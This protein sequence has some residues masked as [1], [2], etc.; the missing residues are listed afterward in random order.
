MS[1]RQGLLFTAVALL[2]VLFSVPGSSQEVTIQ[3]GKASLLISMLANTTWPDEDAI[4]TWRVG[5]YGRDRK[6]MAVLKRDLPRYPTRGKPVTV[7]PY[8]TLDDAR[9]AHI[10][11]V[12]PGSN[13]DLKEI[14]RAL[15]GSQTLIVTDGAADLEFSM[16]NFTHPSSVRLGFEINRSNI[17]DAG[18]QLSRDMLLFGGSKLDVAAVYEETEAELERTRALARQRQQQMEA[19][20][21]ELEQQRET[22]ARQRALVAMNEEELKALGDQ[23]SG[24]QQVLEHSESRL[25]QNAALLEEKERVLAEKEAYIEGYSQRIERNLQRLAEQQ[26]AIGEQEEKIAEQERVLVRQLGTIESQRL[27]LAGAIVGLLLVLTLIVVIFRGYRSKHRLNL[28]LEG[29]TREL[30]VANEK[31]VQMTEAKSQ[32]LSTMSHEIRTP[33][34]GVIGMAEL[35]DGTE[36]NDQQREY[37]SLIIKSA[38]TLLGIINDILDFSKIEAGRLDLERVPFNIRDIL[39]D[40]LQTLALRANEKGLELTFH[41]PPAVPESLLG[42]PLRLR[43]VIVNLVGNAIKFTEQGEVAVDVRLDSAEA[44]VARLRF[45][46]R[47]TGIGISPAQ[48][49]RIFEAFGQ[50]DSSTT[51]QFGGTGLGLAIASQL[52]EMMGGRMQ[53][54]SEPGRGSTFSFGADLGIPAA[55]VPAPVH[56]EQL[57]GLKVLV[58]D[59]NHTNRLILEELLHSW[60]MEAIVAEHGTAALALLDEARQA[61]TGLALALLDVMMPQMDGIELATRIRGRPELARMRIIMLSSAGRAESQE[62]RNRLDIS[63]ML[64]KPVKHSD[65]LNAITDAIGV[66]GGRRDSALSTTPADLVA[67]R[68]L[69]VEDNPVNQKVARELLAKRGHAVQLACNGR[70]AV[71]ISAREEFDLVLMDVHMPVMDGLTATRIIR[72]RERSTGVHVPIVALTAGATI[73]DRENCLAAGMNSFVTKPFRAGELFQQVE[74]FAASSAAPV[75]AA[76]EAVTAK[77]AVEEA[78]CLDRAGALRNLDGDEDFFDELVVMFREQCP[79]LMADVEAAVA[80]GDMDSLQR[81]AHGLKGSVQVIGG[82]AAAAAALALERIGR[83]GDAGAAGSA[84][85]VLRTRLTELEKALQPAGGD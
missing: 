69:L 40:T 43:Q 73:E 15:K 21:R 20:Q 16:V 84:L 78:P 12:A 27:I 63:R 19:Q 71:D 48:Q 5:L 42:D 47:D 81:A 25:V 34:N 29:K 54:S 38:D 66:T 55:P 31:L 2:A 72:E 23:L 52:A 36:L 58:V 61:G 75:P 65:L 79:G 26:A 67:R 33:M 57:R 18:L 28:Q 10:L 59:D 82:Q 35:L 14:Y 76:T 74:K 32:F 37:V 7:R 39:G 85:A 9:A 1:V 41:I 46:V 70:E 13:S 50:A 53:I 6:L 8:S 62:V 4:D 44:G 49:R 17:I 83:E 64:M 30:G 80:S 24:V 11:V 60:G 56:P 77:P 51:R 22:I 3:D 68:I 45:A